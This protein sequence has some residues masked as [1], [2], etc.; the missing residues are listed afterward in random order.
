MKPWR[1]TGGT[2][3]RLLGKSLR[4][5]LV[6][7]QSVSCFVFRWDEGR[8]PNISLLTHVLNKRIG[9]LFDRMDFNRPSVRINRSSSGFRFS[10]ELGTSRGA[11]QTFSDTSFNFPRVILTVWLFSCPMELFC[12][13]ISF[14]WFLSCV[15]PSGCPC[16]FCIMNTFGLAS[17]QPWW[18]IEYVMMAFGLLLFFLLSASVFQNF[19]DLA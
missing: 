11:L 19:A 9:D 7:V 5:H 8:R 14:S 10:V 16:R 18:V 17:P 4:L 15:A 1:V 13:F 3:I 6:R 12:S 2:S